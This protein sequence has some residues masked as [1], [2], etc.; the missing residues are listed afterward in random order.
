MIDRLALTALAVWAL[1]APALAAEKHVDL[2][3]R[4]SFQRV[5]IDVPPN[6]IGSIV[7]LAGG[8]GVLDIDDRGRIRSLS[9]NQLIRTRAAYVAAGYAVAAPDIAT[10]LK[11]TRSYRAA[12]THGQDIAAVIAHM[13]RIKG[14]VALVATSRGAISAATTMLRQSGTLPDALVITSGML[15]GGF[16]AETMGNPANI[17]VPVLLIAHQDDTCSVTLPA[18]MAGY[19]ARLTGSRKV[20][21]ITLSGGPRTQDDPCEAYGPHGFAGIDQKVVDTITNWLKANMR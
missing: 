14:P 18:D 21:T 3:T 4:A 2:P 19:A 16:S 8:L 15:R 10:D 12:S 13:R 11:N 7:L 17:K 5:L 6:P 20:E 9:G 1:S